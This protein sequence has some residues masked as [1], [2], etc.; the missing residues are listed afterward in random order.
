MGRS[1]VRQ[2]WH[3]FTHHLSSLKCGELGTVQVMVWVFSEC[4]VVLCLEYVVIFF[5]SFLFSEE[6][7]NPSWRGCSDP[8][9]TQFSSLGLCS[10]SLSKLS[11]PAPCIVISR[12]SAVLLVP[13]WTWSN[14]SISFFYW[15]VQNWSLFQVQAERCLMVRN[16]HVFWLAGYN[17]VNTSQYAF[18]SHLCQEHGAWWMFSVFSSRI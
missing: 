11:Q 6:W 8:H 4:T 5:N 18:G 15:E 14:V 7:S 1:T 13:R 12:P 17:F 9:S 10:L 2:W 16:N 3:Q